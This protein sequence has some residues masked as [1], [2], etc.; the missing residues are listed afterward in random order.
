MLA[1]AIR[2]DA[3]YIVTRNIRHFLIASLDPFELRALTPDAFLL[4]LCAD[5]SALHALSE[6]ILK[7]S[8]SLRRPQLTPRQV[9]KALRHDIPETS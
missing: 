3:N 2:A 5:P 1:A 6:T 4:E 7:Q 8:Q 9:L